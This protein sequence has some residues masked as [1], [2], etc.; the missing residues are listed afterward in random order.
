[1][2]H[3]VRRFTKGSF[4]VINLIVALCFLLGSYG[5]LFNPTQ[6]W[7]IGFLTLGTFYL[8]LALIGFWFFWLLVKPRY[9][10][11]STVAIVFAWAPVQHLLQLKVNSDFDIKKN[12]TT[13]R[14]MSWNVEHFK[15]AEHK[16]NPQKKTEMLRLINMY[17]PDVACFQEMVGSDSVPTA[18]NYLPDIAKELGMPYY[19]YSYNR[20]LDFDNNHRF[21]I[22]TFSRHPI[23]N[24]QSRSFEPNDYNSIFQFVDVKVG[25]AVVRVFN[26][27]FQSLRFSNE[28]LKYIEKPNI[29]DEVDFKKDFN[30]VPNS[31]AYHTVGTGLNSTFAKKGAGIGRT[32][33]HVSPTLRIDNIFADKRFAVLQYVRNKKRISDHFPIVADLSLPKS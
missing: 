27:H 28:D 31:Y 17:Q 8:L 4:V 14:V 7:F 24:K 22:I 19:Y 18:I 2:A 32:F 23:V 29:D 20:K 10:V 9:M 25:T 16:T 30:D 12:P 1:M 33:S 15:I 26:L 13:L 6:W 11:I 3:P 5:Y 21:G